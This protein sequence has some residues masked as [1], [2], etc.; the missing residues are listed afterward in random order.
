MVEVSVSGHLKWG[1]RAHL[2]VVEC[3]SPLK[4]GPKSLASAWGLSAKG[5]GDARPNLRVPHSH[6]LL[7]L[8][9][10]KD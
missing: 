7:S 3:A 10:S 1:R 9:A 2:V 6:F 4:P 8:R 5:V